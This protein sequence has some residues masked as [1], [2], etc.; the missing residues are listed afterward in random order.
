MC[1]QCNV[2]TFFGETV[3]LWTC[4]PV[5]SHRTQTINNIGFVYIQLCCKISSSN[6]QFHVSSKAFNE[7]RP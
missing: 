1:V 7:Y 4:R 3:I 6:L 5:E 2:F